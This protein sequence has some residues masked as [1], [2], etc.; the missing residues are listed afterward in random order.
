[1]EQ[2]ANKSALD[3]F[4]KAHSYDSSRVQSYYYT[5]I[6]I[7]SICY[8]TGKSCTDAIEMLTTSINIDPTF[9]N[10]HYNRGICFQKISMFHEAIDDFNKAIELNPK[11]GECYTNRAISK[12]HLSMKNS[13]CNDLEKALKMGALQAKSLYNE[14]C[15]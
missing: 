12:F 15:K 11:N 8:E 7:A 10:S 1:M 2:G 14:Y 6:I 5:G 3:M 4:Q 13:G 9:R